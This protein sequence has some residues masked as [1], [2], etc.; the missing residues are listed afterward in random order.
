[1]NVT[2]ARNGKSAL[3]PKVEETTAGPVVPENKDPFHTPRDSVTY[4]AGKMVGGYVPQPVAQYFQLLALYR[5]QSI[6]RT[7]QQMIEE[8]MK[9][10][11]TPAMIIEELAVRAFQEYQRRLDTRGNIPAE[12]FLEDYLLEMGVSMR[13]HRVTKDE[14]VLGVVT[15]LKEL[16]LQE[17]L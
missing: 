5:G 10:K 3:T 13:R 7:L 16:I 12:Q 17:G 14:Y 11:E 8:W 9:D 15:R 4:L 6:Q 2:N 1:M